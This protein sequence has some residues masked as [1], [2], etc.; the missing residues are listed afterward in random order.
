[1]IIE[2]VKQEQKAQMVTR[3]LKIKKMYENFTVSLSYRV[4]YCRCNILNH[5]VQTHSLLCVGLNFIVWLRTINYFQ[6]SDN[7]GPYMPSV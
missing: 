6:P 5:L 3:V 1:M 2:L 7:H 4:I